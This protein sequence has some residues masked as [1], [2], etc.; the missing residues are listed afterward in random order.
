MNRTSRELLV[1]RHAKAEPVA[2]SDH[3][4]R[5]TARGIA[6]ATAAGVWARAGDH[7]PDHALVSSAERTRGTWHAFADGSG[8]T[9]EPAIDRGLYGADPD[10]ALE[11]LRATPDA[12]RR[13][14]VI[15]HNPTMASLVHLLDD[16]AGEPELFARIST[17]YPTS[18]LTV[19]EVPG[20]WA[21]LDLAGARIIAVHLGER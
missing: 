4:R 10:G 2:D 18:A 17:G 9:A 16:G 21:D 19:L 15:G 20:Q 3:D 7:V 13:L 5:L 11:I 1:M 6:D 12:V 8:C 14:L